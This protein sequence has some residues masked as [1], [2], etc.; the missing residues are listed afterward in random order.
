MLQIC[1]KFEIAYI[2]IWLCFAAPTSKGYTKL[3]ASSRFLLMAM[4]CTPSTGCER[5]KCTIFGTKKGPK[6]IQG[7]LFFDCVFCVWPLW[8][9]FKVRH[10]MGGLIMTYSKPQLRASYEVI[11]HPASIWLRRKLY[12]LWGIEIGTF[13]SWVVCSNRSARAL[14]LTLLAWEPQ[15]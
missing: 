14:S 2:H 13:R 7:C 5:V 10:V 8:S 11:L 6:Q 9:L 4:K 3:S 1:C 15:N 12:P